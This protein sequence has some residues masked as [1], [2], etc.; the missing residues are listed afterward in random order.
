MASRSGQQAAQYHY[1]PAAKVRGDYPSQYKF[2]LI[3]TM[4]SS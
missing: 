2:H 4:H 3:M 1:V